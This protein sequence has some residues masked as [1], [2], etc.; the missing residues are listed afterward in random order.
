MGSK[1]PISTAEENRQGATHAVRQ[2]HGTLQSF[3]PAL[4]R[5]PC[6]SFTIKRGS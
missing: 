2:T 6:A 5:V 1:A 3:F 4:L